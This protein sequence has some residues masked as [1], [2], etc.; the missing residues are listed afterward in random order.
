[1]VAN[2]VARLER[3]EKQSARIVAG[4]PFAPLSDG[5]LSELLE[6]VR[7]ICDGGDA[8]KA[9]ADA[10]WLRLDEAKRATFWRCVERVPVNQ[11]ARPH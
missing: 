10:R 5:D 2:L 7:L 11:N 8:G 3:L 4:D 9:D 6:L 1:M